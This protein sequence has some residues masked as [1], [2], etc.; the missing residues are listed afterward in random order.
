MKNNKLIKL[1]DFLPKSKFK[2]GSGLKE[3]LYPFYTS[4]NTLSKYLNNYLYEPECLVFGTGGKASIHFAVEK[5]STS[6]DCIVIKSKE[7][8]AIDTNYVYQY[9]KVNFYVIEQ[10]FKGAGLKH[11]SKAY[12]ADIQIYYPEKINDQIRIAT[13]LS[14]IEALI[15]TRKENLKLLDEFL[16]ST[17][18][19]MFGD[20]VSNERNWDAKELGQV[21]SDIDSGWSPKCEARPTDKEEWGVLKLGAVTYCV[22][23]DSENKALPN[24]V[25]P[26]SEKEVHS[27]DLLF[28]RKNTYNLVGACAY[29]FTTKPKLMMPDLIFRLVIKNKN[30]IKPL[31]LWKLLTNSRQRKLVQSLAGGA[32]GSMPNISKAKLRTTKIII[33]PPELQEKF[34]NIVEKVESIKNTFLGNLTDLENLYGAV[35]QKAFKGELDLSAIP[36][37]AT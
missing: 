28:T 10:G 22:Y 11:I 37:V 4:S 8:V 23:N 21:L 6:T 3:G 36:V 17:F 18:L 1:F 2:A 12:L 32:A 15:T 29:V 33:P 30:E 34:S 9:L 27:G 31:F 25:T 26:K 14:R 13:L 16:K 19:E 24:N 20:P 35:S 7:S 5:F